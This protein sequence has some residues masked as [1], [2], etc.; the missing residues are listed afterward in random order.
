MEK[1]LFLQALG[2]KEPWYIKE[3]KL[4]IENERLDIYLDFEKG[5]KFENIDGD[6][7]TAF[8]TVKRHGNTYFLAVPNISSCKS[9]QIKR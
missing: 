5:T 7:V 3:V 9:T 4:D 2:L 6:Y 8:Q 1:E